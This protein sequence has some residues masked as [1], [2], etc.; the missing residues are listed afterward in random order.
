MKHIK[1]FEDFQAVSA[2]DAAKSAA[3]DEK[4]IAD[5]KVEDI[6]SKYFGDKNEAEAE[7]FLQDL[8]K[9]YGEDAN[10]YPRWFRK[11]IQWLKGNRKNMGDRKTARVKPKKEMRKNTQTF[12][13]LT[14]VALNGLFL[15][16]FGPS[17]LRTLEAPFK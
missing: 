3:E 5:N 13:S 7:K 6:A 16:V 9:K 4:L 2:Q 11:L 17:L 1:L 10:A 8:K 12:L 15:K 14:V